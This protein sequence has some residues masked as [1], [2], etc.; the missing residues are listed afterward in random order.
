M[1]QPKLYYP[2]PSNKSDKKFMV[3]TKNGLI[4]FGAKGYHHYTQ[5]HLDEKRRIL[6][7]KRHKTYENWQDPNTAGF[8]SYR[9]LWKYKTYDEAMRHIKSYI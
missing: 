9:Y 5:D 6:Y 7:V 3:Y 4:Y 8:W 1:T 2:Y